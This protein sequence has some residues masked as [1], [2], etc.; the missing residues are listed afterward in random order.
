MHLAH[1]RAE[2]AGPLPVQHA[3]LA[4]AVPLRIDLRILFPE[5]LPRPGD[6]GDD[7]VEL[8]TVSVV[9]G[10]WTEQEEDKGTEQCG[11]G[12]QPEAVDKIAC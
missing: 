2:P 5:Q 4:V 9:D 12:H 10:V 11:E 3:E 7:G 6:V 1:R 8:A